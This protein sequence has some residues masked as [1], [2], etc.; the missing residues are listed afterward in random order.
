MKPRKARPLK[1]GDLIYLK[2][3]GFPFNRTDNGCE[4][5][6][7]A[8]CVVISSKA[9]HG[10]GYIQVE[11]LIPVRCEDGHGVMSSCLFHPEQC[12]PEDRPW[13]RKHFKGILKLRNQLNTLAD[14]IKAQLS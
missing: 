6:E 8:S 7:G 2:N 10:G 3:V 5:W 14:A 1:V 13:L 11:P 4:S 9:G 12:I